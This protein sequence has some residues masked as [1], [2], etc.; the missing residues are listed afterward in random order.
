MGISPG[1]RAASPPLRGL[2]L[3]EDPFTRAVERASSCVDHAQRPM[4]PT[5]LSPANPP[6]SEPRH[7]QKSPSRV[8]WNEPAPAQAT[9][10]GKPPRSWGRHAWGRHASTW[11]HERRSGAKVAQ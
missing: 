10:G 3:A 5:E 8:G 9:H 2:S 7:L 11:N 1:A 4:P 6:L